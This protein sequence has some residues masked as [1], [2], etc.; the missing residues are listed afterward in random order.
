VSEYYRPSG[1]FQL[2]GL[3][4]T[5]V[6]GA[7]A[8]LV[9]AGV[10]GYLILYNPFLYINFMATL[11]LGFLVGVAASAGVSVGKVRNSLVASLLGAGVGV[12]AVYVSWVVWV[13]ALAGRADESLWVVDPTAL[14]G[15][16]GLL[17]KEGVWSIR[18]ATPTGVVLYAIWA[19]EALIVIGLVVAAV[20]GAASRPFCERCNAWMSETVGQKMLG[21]VDDRN[22]LVD[23]LEAGRFDALGAL[24]EPTAERF[25]R[26]SL[27]ECPGEGHAAYLSIRNVAV[28]TDSK[29]KTEEKEE[30]VLAHLEV[31]PA[32]RKILDAVLR[33]PATAASPL[34]I[35]PT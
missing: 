5:V 33:E 22:G 34:E 11:G 25:S 20:H 30:A 19:S 32:R 27:A 28:T 23:A 35:S 2:S 17:A 10:Y 4:L 24:G 13:H 7:A 12:I 3:L 29:G 21:Y 26:S 14:L 31:E 8:A 9:C 18:S 16:V 1:L 6:F 15:V